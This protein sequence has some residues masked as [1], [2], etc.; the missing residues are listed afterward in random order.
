MH[1]IQDAYI[2][3][4]SQQALYLRLITLFVETFAGTNV[5]ASPVRGTNF[6]ALVLFLLSNINSHHRKHKNV[7]FGK[8]FRAVKIPFCAKKW[9]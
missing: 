9:Y 4:R 3:L 1:K 7:I 2:V 5:R 6:L 8:Y